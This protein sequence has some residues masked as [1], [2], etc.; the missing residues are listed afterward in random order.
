MTP[1]QREPPPSGHHLRIRGHA[2]IPGALTPDTPGITVPVEITQPTE[3][4]MSS[5]K[6]ERRTTF[7]ARYI[8]DGTFYRW[9]FWRD[10]RHPAG[11]MLRTHDGVERCIGTTWSD[12]HPRIN[13]IADNYGMS[14]E[15]S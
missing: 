5:P 6:T 8:G 15:V 2:M 11:W 12:A 13:A 9:T 7:R 10:S 3:D 14:V 4:K 1:E